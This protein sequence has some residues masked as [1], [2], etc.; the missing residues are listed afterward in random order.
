[1]NIS[2][3]G[4]FVYQPYQPYHQQQE[5][6]N[7]TIKNLFEDIR[8]LP[9]QRGPSSQDDEGKVSTMSQTFRV[10]FSLLVFADLQAVAEGVQEP[11][12]WKD[13]NKYFTLQ[14]GDAEKG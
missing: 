6:P 8:E 5:K 10:T 11:L 7:K 12:R 3:E 14:L 2:L 13:L 1:M 4:H 9:R